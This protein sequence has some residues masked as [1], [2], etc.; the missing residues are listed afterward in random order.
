MQFL[1][2]YRSIDDPIN[3]IVTFFIDELMVLLA[4]LE[5][6]GQTL[7]HNVE[8]LFILNIIFLHGESGTSISVMICSAAVVLSI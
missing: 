7:P 6:V 8:K 4:F 2:G 3:P 5:I 1:A